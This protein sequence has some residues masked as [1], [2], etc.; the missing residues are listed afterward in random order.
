M[1]R[2]RNRLILVFLLAT[3]LPLCLTLWTTLSLLDWSLN[4]APLKELD[5]VSRSLLA[6]GREL[7]QQSGEI[8]KRDASEGRV[9][10][11]KLKPEQAQTFWDSGKA[12]Q[13]ERT[14]N[15]GDRLEYFVR[16]DGEVWMY[17]RPLGVA[18]ERLTREYTDARQVIA[19][20]EQRNLRR[21][22]SGALLVI[23]AALW[24]AALGA[25][26]YLA[27]RISRPVRQLTQGL[28]RVAA[29]DLDAR[30]PRA[31]PMK[32]ARPCVRLTIWRTSCSRLANG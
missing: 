32:L 3:V 5:A 29:G 16:H 8:L 4:L 21:G 26:V 10:P 30:V 2:L 14:G 23:V 24:I 18:T 19:T 22:L 27:A 20:S 6:T 11:V 17:S 25:L 9:A 28:G 31:A 1:N 12:E 15:D 13:F 7:Y